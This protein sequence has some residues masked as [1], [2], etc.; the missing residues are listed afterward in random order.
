MD[1]SGFFRIY[2]KLSAYREQ[3]Q[4]SFAALLISYFPLL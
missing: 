4:T 3:K 2:G 1:F